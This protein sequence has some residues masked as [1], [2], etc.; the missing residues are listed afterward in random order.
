MREITA[1]E[2]SVGIYDISMDVKHTFELA[3]IADSK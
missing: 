3:A 1:G 2:L